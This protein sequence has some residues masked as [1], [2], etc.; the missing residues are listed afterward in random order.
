MLHMLKRIN[1]VGHAINAKGM[2]EKKLSAVKSVERSDI[3]FNALQ[4]GN[5]KFK[6]PFYVYEN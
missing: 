4:D 6:F 5:K 2:T 3:V 1:K